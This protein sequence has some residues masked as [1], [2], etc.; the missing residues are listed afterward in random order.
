MFLQN[1][2]HKMANHPDQTSYELPGSTG[3]TAQL[4]IYVAVEDPADE[5]YNIKPNN[6]IEA[7]R[8]AM[9][10]YAKASQLSLDQVYPGRYRCGTKRYPI[11]SSTLNA[12]NMAVV[13][14][15]SS[16]AQLTIERTNT[17][18]SELELRARLGNGR[19]DQYS[20]KEEVLRAF[21]LAIASLK[22]QMRSYPHLVT[23][24][25]LVVSQYKDTLQQLNVSVDKLQKV[26]AEVFNKVKYN[27]PKPTRKITIK[28]NEQN[29]SHKE[30]IGEA[31][32]GVSET[33]QREEQEESQEVCGVP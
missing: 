32:G 8:D 15:G 11:S 7:I 12:Y 17:E 30:G 22:V 13:Y 23:T 6:G 3:I 25:P 28:Y 4:H 20:S 27:T 19:Y 2:K 10:D 24:A 26:E 5:S 21:D 9:V 1:G 31:S 33:T 29:E 14:Y 18:P 16:L